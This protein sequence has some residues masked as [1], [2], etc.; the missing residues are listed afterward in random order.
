MERQRGGGGGGSSTLQC[1]SPPRLPSS[2][3]PPFLLQEAH[4]DRCALSSQ[5]RD[6]KVRLQSSGTTAIWI[7][8]G[9]CFH[10]AD[11]KNRR[12]SQ[13]KQVMHIV[14]N[15]IYSI[16]KTNQGFTNKALTSPGPFVYSA[17]YSSDGAICHQVEV[18][19]LTSYCPHSDKDTR[20]SHAFRP[21]QRHL[22]ASC[23]QK[24]S[25]TLSHHLPSAIPS[26]RGRVAP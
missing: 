10:T 12:Q 8:P 6:A 11:S 14:T 17:P 18:L 26:R 2:S 4:A 24:I 5:G 13:A 25:N 19:I 15:G 3:P 20:T 23:W 1:L 21:E 7:Q 9:C 16:T 22:T